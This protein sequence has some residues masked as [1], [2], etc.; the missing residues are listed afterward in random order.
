MSVTR[1]QQTEMKIR[2]MFEEDRITHFEVDP[3]A[4]SYRVNEKWLYISPNLLPLVRTIAN[5]FGFNEEGNRV[6][7]KELVDEDVEKIVSELKSNKWLESEDL[8]ED[9]DYEDLE[10]E[11]DEEFDEDEEDEAD[12][13]ESTDEEE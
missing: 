2:K 13:F 6:T 11:D 12:L 4:M 9:E 10:D 3:N 5:D 8:D 1:S 7:V